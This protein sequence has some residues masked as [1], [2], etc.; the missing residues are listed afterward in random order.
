MSNCNN[1]FNGCTETVSDQCVRYTGI[2]VPTLGIQT[3]DPLSVIEQSL[4]TF[5][6]S[7]LDGSG[8]KIDLNGIDICAVIQKYLPTCGEISIEDISKALIEAACDIQDQVNSIFGTLA[9]L[10]SDYV[11]GCLTGVTASSDTHAIVQAIIT[12]LCSIDY[13]LTYTIN[14]LSSYVL[15]SELCTLVEDCVNNNSGA[16]LASSKMLPY[17]VIPYY[18]AISGYPTV[19]DGFSSTGAGY[20]YWLNVYVCNGQNPGVPDLRGRVAVGSTDMFGSNWPTQTNPAGPGNP[21]YGYK[22]STSVQGTNTITLSLPQIP[23]HDHAG[24]TAITT[25]SP[26]THS[27]FTVGPSQSNTLTSSNTISQGNGND[28]NLGYS[29][30]GFNGAATIGKSSDV[31]LSATTTLTMLP[32]GQGQAHS[33]VQPGLAVYY[34]IYIPA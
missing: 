15:K 34:L 26:A 6:V 30:R 2:D 27:H 18:G 33:N 25:I 19:S 22:T 11:I 7:A 1:C 28:G 23:G 4:I 5:L 16:A 21:T 32:N 12:K 9:I 20:G 17:S 31:A 29:L 10:N 3:G 13:T 8:I 14:Q 24:S